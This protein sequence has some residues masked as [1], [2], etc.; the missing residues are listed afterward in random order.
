[1]LK[2]TLTRQVG[3]PFYTLGVLEEPTTGFRCK[4]LERPVEEAKKNPR[5]PFVAVP[6]GL[7]KMKV[8]TL[9]MD[10]T[11]GF[12]LNGSLHNAH[13]RGDTSFAR[14]PAGSVC[15]GKSFNEETGLVGAEEVGKRFSQ[16]IEHLIDSGVLSGKNKKGEM[17][18]EI[19]QDE[20]FVITKGKD[21]DAPKG[22][23]VKPN[24]D[25]LEESGEE[26]FGIEWEDE[27]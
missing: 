8:V 21:P 22:K 16:L 12:C 9:D 4:T 7:H 17:M 27:L 26:D 1:M 2:F 5:K 11:I 13:L 23:K 19:V 6:A 15:I 20:S 14:I 18:M 3:T 10:F 25:C 24:W